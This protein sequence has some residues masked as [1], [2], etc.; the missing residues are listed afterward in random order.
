MLEKLDLVKQKEKE[1]QKKGKLASKYKKV[2]Q[3]VGT[4]E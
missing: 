2:F 4:L 1:K 3:I